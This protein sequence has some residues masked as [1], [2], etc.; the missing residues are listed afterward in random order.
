MGLKMWRGIAFLAAMAA[1]VVIYTGGQEPAAAQTSQTRIP[2]FEVD[3]N[4]PDVPADLA[5]GQVGGIDAD[6]QDHVWVSSRPTSVDTQDLLGEKGIADCCKAA[7]PIME[8][9][10]NGKFVRGWG[11]PAPNG[12]YDWMTRSSKPA[13]RRT[14]DSTAENGEH[15]VHADPKGNVWVGGNGEGDSSILKFT[16]E[17]KFVM[18]IGKHGQNKGSNDT[19]NVNRS[20]GY[21]YSPKTNELFVADGYGNRRVIVFDADTGA[22]KRHWGA[23]GKPPDD[24]APRTR[25]A[26]GP[27]P[28]QFNTVHG[29]AIAND[30]MVYVADRANN[31][32][33]VFNLNGTFV[34][35]VFIARRTVQGP[36]TA[37]DVTLSHEPDQRYLYVADGTNAHIMILDRQTLQI[38][39]QVG[40]YGRQSGRFF[41]L[42][43]ITSDSKGNLYT[44]E[45]LGMRVQKFVFKG[46]TARP[47]ST[48]SR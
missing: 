23:Y 22:Y 32:V 3:P 35:E 10:Q 5:M 27:P 39:G 20:A 18:Q 45:S 34:K 11:G 31:R 2:V 41:H 21:T 14:G 28:Q 15:D 48:S 13:S 43:S 36:G 24:A 12:E 4:W 46:Y 44:G 6:A 8:F 29:I 26:D 42:H 33:Q 9:D 38:L 40:R 47:T 19:Q 37:F 16:R 1:L 7:P 25:T 17:G 30:G